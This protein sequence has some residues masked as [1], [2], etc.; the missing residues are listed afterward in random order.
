MDVQQ[1]IRRCRGRYT[2]AHQRGNSVIVVEALP[3]PLAVP[4]AVIKGCDW[5]ALY[6]HIDSVMEGVAARLEDKHD[7]S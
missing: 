1:F 7:D 6:K 2:D 3:I 4:E 5:D